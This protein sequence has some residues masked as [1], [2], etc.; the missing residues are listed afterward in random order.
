MYEY[1]QTQLGADYTWPGNVR[2]LDQCVRNVL[3]RQEYRPPRP[4]SLDPHE[5]LAAALADGK[6]SADDVL[7]RYCAL[8]YKQCGSYQETARRVGLDRRTVKTRVQASATDG[9]G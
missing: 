9:P 1:I 4:V 3:V 2:E 6:L 8:V 5:Q 7:S